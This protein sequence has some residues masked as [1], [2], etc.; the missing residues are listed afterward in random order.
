MITAAFDR[1]RMTL[2]VQGHALYADAGKDIVCAGASALVF[3]LT[4]Q[5]QNM[6][7]AG[8]VKDVLHSVHKGDYTLHVQLVDEESRLLVQVAFDTIRAGFDLLAA[9]YPEHIKIR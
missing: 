8:L 7:R 1:D 3:A 5:M 2:K 6:C 4:E 9:K